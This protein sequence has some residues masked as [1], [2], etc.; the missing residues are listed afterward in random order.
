MLN[1]RQ[2][3][4]NRFIQTD[5]FKETTV[6]GVFACGDAA[7]A[8][9]SVALAVADGAMSGTAAHQSLIFRDT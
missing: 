6:P 9:G 3:P 2:G 1:N 5:G 8:F 7:R 4:L